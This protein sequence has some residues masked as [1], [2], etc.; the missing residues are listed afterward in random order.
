M[1]NGALEELSGA[2]LLKLRRWRSDGAP[3]LYIHGATFP[4][5]LSVGYRFDDGE[6]WAS[7]LFASGFDVWALDFAGYGESE[8]PAAFTQNAAS[9]TPIGT[10][11]EAAPQIARAVA[12]IR[13]ARDG[14]RVNIIAHSWGT[15]PASAFAT[16]APDAVDRLVLFGPILRRAPEPS[17]SKAL[18]PL[19][20][21]RLITVED[22]RARFEQDTPRDH[23]SVLAEPDLARWGAAWL[24]T[25]PAAAGRTPPAVKTPNGP[26]A[27]VQAMWSGAWLYEPA[28]IEAPTLIVRGEWDSLCTDGDVAGFLAACKGRARADV[29]L[30]RGGHLMH[31]ETGRRAL[32]RAANT[33][34]KETP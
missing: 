29:K 15:I 3:V 22:Q 12:H 28:R 9:A 31:L 2:P 11:A 33:F 7:A 20:A 6:S 8:K 4:S 32:W 10:S 21:W 19:P 34:L 25:D 14:A 30:P 23:A 27:N 18:S 5:A 24:A 13:S 26:A 1:K 17:Q 16:S